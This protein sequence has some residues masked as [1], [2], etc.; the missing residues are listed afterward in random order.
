MLKSNRWRF[1]VQLLYCTSSVGYHNKTSKIGLSVVLLSL[2]LSYFQQYL[3]KLTFWHIS[4]NFKLKVK[5]SR[6]YCLC[7]CKLKALKT[8]S[9]Y[10]CWNIWICFQLCFPS[11]SKRPRFLWRPAGGERPGAPP[12]GPQSDTGLLFTLFQ[13]PPQRHEQVWP[14]VPFLIA[15]CRSSL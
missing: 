3:Y 6:S 15:F 13:Q 9:C 11:P 10:L 8:T 12:P 7:N 5:D 4:N 14:L 1:C 2:F